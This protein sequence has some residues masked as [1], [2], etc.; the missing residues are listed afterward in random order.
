M[1]SRIGWGMRTVACVLLLALIG[2]GRTATVTGK[3]TYKGR[4]V[5]YGTVVC[6]S[7]DKKTRSGVIEP[8]GTYKVEQVPFGDTKV[9]VVSRDPSKGR[10]TVRT[11]KHDP[12]DKPEAALPPS[13]IENWVPLPQQYELPG[14]SGLGCSVEATVVNYDIDLK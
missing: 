10:S 7:V 8:D 6:V 11:A 5:C 9:V 12:A 14:S 1:N 13:V 2:C 3:V 4:P